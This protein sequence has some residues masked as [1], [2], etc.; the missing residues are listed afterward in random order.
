M[1]PAAALAFLLIACG[2]L[3]VERG[4]PR[5]RRAAW[6]ASA[7]VAVLALLGFVEE[8]GNAHLAAIPARMSFATCATLLVL[9]IAVPMRRDLR[10]FGLSANAIAASVISAVGFF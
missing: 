4:G 10:V 2:Y 3:A 9:A 8:L 5:A 6:T 7:V 1:A